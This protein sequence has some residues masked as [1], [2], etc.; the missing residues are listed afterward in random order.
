MAEAIALAREELGVTFDGLELTPLRPALGVEA[1]S[2]RRQLLRRTKRTGPTAAPYAGQAYVA[3]RFSYPGR[4]RA[5]GRPTTGRL[6]F[7]EAALTE[8]IPWDVQAYAES[9]LTFPDDSTLDQFFDHR[10]FE[11]YRRLGEF[12]MANA[13]ASDTWEG[14]VRQTALPAEGSGRT[15]VAT[16]EPDPTIDLRDDEGYDEQRDVEAVPAKPE[17]RAPAR[18]AKRAA[19]GDESAA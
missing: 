3:A 14:L 15:A 8:D 10:Q 16:A 4:L 12:Q 11:S 1:P 18:R 19:T 9:R 6:L 13:L 7:V 2:G 17:R 5:D